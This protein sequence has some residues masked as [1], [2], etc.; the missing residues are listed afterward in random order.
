MPEQ[1]LE[2][3]WGAGQHRQRMALSGSDRLPGENGAS[4]RQLRR[5]RVGRARCAGSQQWNNEIVPAITLFGAHRC[6]SVVAQ[7]LWIKPSCA[8]SAPF[9]GPVDPDASRTIAELLG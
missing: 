3:R 4:A 7:E 5:R 8:T 9:D 1:E 6:H 2:H